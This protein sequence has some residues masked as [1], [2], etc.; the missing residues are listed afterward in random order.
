[1]MR[2]DL[3]VFAG[4]SHPGLARAICEELGLSQGRCFIRRFSNENIKV[5]IEENVR[6]SDTF[7]VQTSCPPVSEGIIELLIFID[8][9]KHASAGRITAVL[10]YYPYARSDKKDEP[11]ISI[12]A[13]LMADLLEAA[14]ADRVL[15][16]DL[17]SPQI[18]G[19]FRIPVDHLTA[20]G[21]LCGHFLERGLQGWVLVAPDAG[22]AKDAGRYAKRLDIPLAII[23]KRRYGDDENARA[24]H[25]IGEVGGKECLVVDDEVATAGTLMETVRIL[26]D[27]G[28]AG[29]T[30]GVVHPV[31]SGPAPERVRQS[32]LRE[33]VV[34][35]TIPIPES[36]RCDK[37]R[38]LTVAHLF[39]QAIERIHDGRSVSSLF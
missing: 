31:L 6:G 5:K 16:M 11:R 32:S 13:R 30:A 8:A 12:T 36:N 2:Q 19:F 33:L 14:G 25:I 28:A 20:T 35:D 22:E 1:M 17:H 4:S 18:H 39:A 27:N 23:D 21:V 37:I 38:V 34:T 3:Q 10:P 15:T 9:L 7:V 29:V 24:I 26:L